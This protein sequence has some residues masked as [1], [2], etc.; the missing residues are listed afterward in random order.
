LSR[1]ED[2]KQGDRF[3]GPGAHAATVGGDAWWRAESKKFSY[4]F[5]TTDALEAGC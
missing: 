1:R 2:L 5:V 3:P 4:E